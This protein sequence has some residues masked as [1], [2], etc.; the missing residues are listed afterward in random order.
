[1]EVGQIDIIDF[2]SQLEEHLREIGRDEESLT[3][4]CTQYLKW[5]RTLEFVKTRQLQILHKE[6]QAV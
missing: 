2:E 1:M 5:L 4:N 6:I 3:N